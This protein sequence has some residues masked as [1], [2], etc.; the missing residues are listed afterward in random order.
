MIEFK[1]VCEKNIS[2]EWNLITSLSITMIESP[3]CIRNVQDQ[4]FLVPASLI[5]NADLEKTKP[6]FIHISWMMF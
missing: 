2:Y 5:F 4:A 1:N 6:K 3:V